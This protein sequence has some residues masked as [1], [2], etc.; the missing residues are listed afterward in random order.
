VINPSSFPSLD[1]RGEGRVK[2][3]EETAMATKKSIWILI[4]M[5]VITAW[6]LGSVTQAG[7]Q[8]YTMKCRNTGH[9]PKLHMIEV[10]D[11]PGHI[12]L[13]GETAGV[14]SCDDGSVPTY[15]GKFMGDLTKGSG[16]SQG[17]G[18]VTFE[19]G[20]TQWFNFQQTITPDPD[21]KTASW[22]GTGEYLNGT[23]RF[24]GIQGSVTFTGKRLALFPGVG[25][26]FYTD[27]TNNYTLP[28]K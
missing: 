16:K 23:G 18:V 19:D 21:G 28:S 3:K 20:S 2:Q 9:F 1:K 5:V 17:Y 6:L 13:V 15:S 7:A 24:E 4:G 10:G 14:M 8:T 25:A 27:N 12:V 26:Q 22:E 11:V